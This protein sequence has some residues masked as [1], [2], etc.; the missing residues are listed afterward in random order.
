MKYFVFLMLPLAL[1]VYSCGD[2]SSTSDNDSST[3][4]SDE[5][6]EVVVD[7][8]AEILAALNFPDSHAAVKPGI[9]RPVENGFI[10][11]PEAVVPPQ[12]YTR[13]EEKYNPCI[14]CHQSYPY[15][16]RP[17]TMNDGT[18]QSSYDFSDI[19]V[20]NHWLNLF[21]DRSDRVAAI[22]DQEVIDYLASDNYSTLIEQLKNDSSWSGPIPEIANL[23][24][25]AAAFDEQGFARDGSDWVA[26]NYKPL[27]STFW[28]TNGSTDD[29]ILRLPEAFRSQSCNGIGV[30]RDTYIANLA[31]LEAAIKD[32]DSIT[33][34][35]VNEQAF[36]TD[37]NGDG[38]LGVVTSIQRP[39]FYVGDASAVPVT[40]MLYPEGT[41]FIHTVRYVGIE[42]DGNITLPARMKEV[43][44]MHK[45]SFIEAARLVNLYDNERQE[46]NDGLLPNYISRGDDGIDNGFGWYVLGFIEAREG[47]LRKQ[48]EEE[49]L[50]CMGCH[51]TI[52]STIDQTFAFPR[53]VTGAAGWGYIDTRGMAD[54]PNV[55]SDQDEILHYL[56]TVGGGDEFRQNSEMLEKWFNEDGSINKQAIIDADVYTLITPS[57]RRALTLNKAY[58]S[59]VQ[60]QDYIHGRDATVT[61]ASNVYSEID[62]DTAPVLPTEKLQK[63]DIRLEW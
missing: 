41:E 1:V 43:R 59:I 11:N 3:N 53:K 23:H 39:A 8:E 60:D 12:C 57:V 29:V 25:G 44:Y 24:L 46:K 14:T 21:E 10:Y 54:A 47:H 16:D 15:G 35:P 36:C 31:I 40:A 17:N 13:H 58:M 50:F 45:H 48:S 63:W 55:G 42:S 27:P 7:A 38:Q 49:Q 61:P 52:G 2:S 26:F 32:L 6:D 56:K 18:L 4:D 9:L 37:L 51:T 28:P 5:V 19:G 22:S 33:L 30:S 62:P 20:H 34:P